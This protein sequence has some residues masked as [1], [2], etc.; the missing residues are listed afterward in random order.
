MQRSVFKMMGIAAA[1]LALCACVKTRTAPAT[2]D[3]GPPATTAPA[4]QA[5]RVLRA[6]AGTRP[7]PRLKN[8]DDVT[9]FVDAAGA[10]PVARREELRQV[11]GNARDDDKIAQR[12]IAQFEDARKHDFSRALVVLALLGE[13][14]NPTGTAYL[15]KFVWQPLPKGGPVREELGLS[16]AAEAQE[17]LQVKA[18]NAIPYARTPKAL[19]AT[20]EIAGRHPL[21]AVRLEAAS[22]YL[23][24]QGNSEEARRKLS[25]VL[26]R[27]ELPVLDRPVRDAGMS[28]RDFNR[29]LAIYLKRHPE[30]QPPNPEKSR[31]QK[32]RQ[33]VDP[34][35]SPPPP[36]AS[37]SSGQ[38]NIP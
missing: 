22:S 35:A 24:N 38:R 20:L 34:T 9:A 16:A 14:R 18:A 32:P 36:D 27:D 10:V 1:L 17:R 28:A 21:K 6:A 8:G 12:L 23:W 11:I 25:A 13:Q 26:R 30:L 29:E 33:A 2:S 3:A 31:Q 19:Q 37:L 7:L 5:P 4:G 15:I